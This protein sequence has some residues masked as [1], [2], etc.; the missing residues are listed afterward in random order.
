M[1]LTP[2][3]QRPRVRWTVIVP[4]A[5]IAFFSGCVTVGSLTSATGL[6]GT[7]PLA[8]RSA[9]REIAEAKRLIDA[10]EYT[11]AIPQLLHTISVYPDAKDSLD[12]RYLLGITYYHMG[13]YKDALDMFNDYMRL[14]PNGT[15]IEECKRELAK[16]TDEYNLKFVP[17][18]QL[19][20]EIKALQ[21]KLNNQT[22]TLEDQWKLADLLWKRGSY[23]ES[24]RLYARI[25]QEHP[26]K[27]TDPV[28]TRRIERHANGEFTVLTPT[29]IQRRYAEQNPLDTVNLNSFRSGRDLFTREPLYYVV[30][31][32]V[33]NR[34]DSV[35][36]G[37][38][39]AVTIY[40]FGNVV[41]DTTTVNIGR[42]NPGEIRAFSVRFHNFENIE[43][44][45]RY[46]AVPTCQR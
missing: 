36:Y 45:F 22:D 27:A 4:I 26:E 7:S 3:S 19:D 35:L 20:Q 34:G 43:N 18:E 30:T 33:V 32:Q 17:P 41:F 29:E 10:G 23:Q 40:G 15:Y 12:A 31:G 46:E 2:S 16:L 5:A 8:E 21:A 25:V 6:G 37:V 13:S 44:I 39:V 9:H 14:A 42:M 24:G 1:F 38:Q 11:E 28:V